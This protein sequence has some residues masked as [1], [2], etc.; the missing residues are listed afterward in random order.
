MRAPLNGVLYNARTFFMQSL[1]VLSA[2]LRRTRRP[3]TAHRPY[4]EVR[5]ELGAGEGDD[6]P[7]PLRVVLRELHQVLRR[8]VLRRERAVTAAN[9]SGAMAAVLRVPTVGTTEFEG[10]EIR[11]YSS[12]AVLCPAC[13]VLW[14]GQEVC[15]TCG[16]SSVKS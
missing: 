3:V 6:V 12:V 2:C 15:L 1:G 10:R 8:G 11:A 4:P 5:R 9:R 14:S 16:R 13:G 7:A